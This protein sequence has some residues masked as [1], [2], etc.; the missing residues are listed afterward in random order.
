LHYIDI[1]PAALATGYVTLVPG[2]D[3][4]RARLTDGTLIE[5][6]ELRWSD[7]NAGHATVTVLDDFAPVRSA[8]VA[9]S[10]AGC[11]RSPL[12]AR[13]FDASHLLAAL[14]T[15]LDSTHSPACCTTP[16]HRACPRSMRRRRSAPR[17]LAEPS[18][19]FYPLCGGCHATAERTPPNF[20]AGSAERVMANLR[21]CAPRIYVRLAMWRRAPT[22]R[23]ENSDAASDP[24][25]LSAHR[26]RARTASR[27]S[28]SWRANGCASRAAANHDSTRC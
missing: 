20:L 14:S 25:D 17:G 2:S 23:R 21:R 3:R 28:N 18:T 13:P 19:T 4:L 27:R 15:R 1:E 5:R 16:R 10:Q 24:F 12:S 7:P 6:I 9:L 22:Q 8:I 11:R 26:D